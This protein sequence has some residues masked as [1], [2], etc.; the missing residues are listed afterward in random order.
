M[1]EV[2]YEMRQTL[3]GEECAYPDIAG[4]L[5]ILRLVHQNQGKLEDGV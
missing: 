5:N 3:Q 2:C 1:R 4:F